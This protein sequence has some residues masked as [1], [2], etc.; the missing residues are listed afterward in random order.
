VKKGAAVLVL[1]AI[2]SALFLLRPSTPL[3][4]SPPTLAQH[5]PPPPT[6]R[7]PRQKL[8]PILAPAEGKGVP[9]AEIKAAMLYQFLKL[10]PWPPPGPEQVNAPLRVG[11][12]GISPVGDHLHRTAMD[13]EI[14]HR[15]IMVV[16]GSDLGELPPC[17]ILFIPFGW[18]D[19]W[20]LILPAVPKRGVLIVGEEGGFLE[21]G[22]GIA[23][24]VEDRKIRYS[25]HLGNIRACGVEPGSTLI[26]LANPLL[27]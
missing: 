14:D 25:M 18:K 24:R 17:H 2:V 23:I 16:R 26:D 21:A 7:K 27:R 15:R 4:T 11:V 8:S 9:E 5:R 6:P 19:D 20:D 10:T 12:L 22:G 13:K 1:I 3:P